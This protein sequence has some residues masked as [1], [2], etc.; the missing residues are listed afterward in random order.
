M[1]K[2]SIPGIC[3]RAALL[4]LAIIAGCTS[5]HNIRTDKPSP[6][7]QPSSF[8]VLT[9]N[10]RVGYGGKDPG[11]NPWE[12]RRAKKKLNPIIRAIASV[13]PDIVGLQEVLG[14]GQAR[15]IAKRL[16]LNFAYAAHPGRGWWG[17]AVLSKFP[18]TDCLSR[19]GSAG[20][21]VLVCEIEVHDRRV[22]FVDVHKNLEKTKSSVSSIMTA[23]NSIDPP[24]I[25]MGDFNI[26]PYDERNLLVK[27]RLADTLYG[28][29]TE[30]AANVRRRGTFVTAR[31]YRIDYVFTD[32]Q[33]FKV[34][35][36]GLIAGVH[37]NAS[38]HIGYWAQISFER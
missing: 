19:P 23:I 11:V 12:L 30:S 28:I 9:Y 7:T 20:R 3:S 38:D 1:G 24:L 36:V 34:E 25:V 15:Q 5:V 8:T 35:D 16:N 13:D 37:D 33:N 10:I 17:L 22:T 21:I 2:H 27:E 14:E 31:N 18:I 6:S 4:L 26:A 32:K 29:R